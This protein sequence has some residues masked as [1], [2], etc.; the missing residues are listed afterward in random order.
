VPAIVERLEDDV[1][2]ESWDDNRAQA[3]GVPWLAERTS[4]A[5]VPGFFQTVGSWDI[6][7][8]QVLG[9]M[10]GGNQ[11]AAEIEIHARLPGNGSEIHDEEL[12][13]WTFGESGKVSRFRHYVDTAKHM[14]AA[15]IPVA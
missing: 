1:S 10:E 4:A 8:F 12:H 2:W 14:A 9:L 6:V 11:V 5:D 15:G 3:A 13:L 7:S